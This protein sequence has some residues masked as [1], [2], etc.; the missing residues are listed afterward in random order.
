MYLFYLFILCIY[1]I[2]LF[3]YLFNFMLCIYSLI[4][5][6][7][8]KCTRRIYKSEKRNIVL[9]SIRNGT[10]NTVNLNLNKFSFKRVQYKC[11]EQHNMR[12]YFQQW[13]M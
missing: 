13:T 11:T 9:F 12:L 1:F 6:T 3:I 8:R 4:D 5:F 2:Y 10:L 7:R